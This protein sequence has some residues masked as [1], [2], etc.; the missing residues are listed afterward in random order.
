MVLPVYLRNKIDG[1]VDIAGKKPFFIIGIG[2]GRPLLLRI[3]EVS[4]TFISQRVHITV[5]S[6]SCYKEIDG[7]AL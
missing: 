3:E 2:I 4:I 5:F 1:F 7:C 6:L